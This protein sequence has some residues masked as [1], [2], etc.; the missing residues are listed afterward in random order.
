MSRAI[1]PRR[2][3]PREPLAN[4][5][6]GLSRGR[7]RVCGYNQRAMPIFEYHCSDCDTRFEELVL[8]RKLEDPN[9]TKCGGTTVEKVHSTFA[10]QSSN[11]SSMGAS[12]GPA[13]GLCGS[14]GVPGPCAMN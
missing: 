12:A 11:G 9:C 7:L 4:G 2:N 1:L 5:T 10:A 6:N 8:S 13:E 14:C 3:G